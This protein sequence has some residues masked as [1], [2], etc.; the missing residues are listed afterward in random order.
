MNRILRTIILT[1]I[2]SFALFSISTANAALVQ[3]LFEG[4]VN[5]EFTDNLSLL[6]GSVSLG[7]PVSGTYTI[8]TSTPDN[9]PMDT[10][11]GSYLGA[12]VASTIS[13]GNYTISY[14]SEETSSL[15]AIFN[16]LEM[17]PGSYWDMYN[18]VANMDDVEGY[19]DVA[20]EFKFYQESDQP[21]VPALSSDALPAY[22]LDPFDFMTSSFHIHSN[23]NYDLVIYG[24]I[25]MT[26]TPVPLPAPL[27]LMG[28]GLIGLAGFRR[29]PKA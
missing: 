2:V 15:I 11:T 5:N 18:Q 10:S 21:V 8:D 17:D 26:S 16:D 9:A 1:L 13:F 7:T 20:A 4:I 28:S 27:L 22:A 24:S 12:I 25:T 19:T 14:K 23:P 29:K 3:I 6:D